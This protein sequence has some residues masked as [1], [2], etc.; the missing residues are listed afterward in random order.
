LRCVY[1]YEDDKV[2]KFRRDFVISFE[3]IDSKVNTILSK[4]D[5]TELE[6]LGGEIFLYTDKVK[7]IFD[8][9]HQCFPVLITT[10]GTIRSRE[11]DEMI[12]HYR[13]VIGVS[14]DDPQTVSR[15]R[16]GI[17]FERALA[18]AKHW[19]SLTRTYICAVIN[20]TNIHRIR[21]TFDFYILEQGCFHGIHFGCVE[22]WMNEYYWQAYE[23]EAERLLSSVPLEV[24]RKIS[25][26][27]WNHYGVNKKE[28]VY[29][30]G[31]EK[32][33]MFNPAK[34]DLSRYRRA[35]YAGYCCY[36][37]RLG[38]TPDPLIPAGVEI[39]SRQD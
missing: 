33:E 12:A 7:Y 2:D 13:P 25:I 11:I 14:L 29:E 21:E 1:C 23:K 19:S 24:L 17:D 22:E 38:L 8:K 5:C 26:S 9:Y 31:I 28:Y 36:C 15:Q 34:M 16:V 30:E 10:N 27:P 39:V 37:K 18:N 3:E 35:R 6:L 4:N 32:I 20:P